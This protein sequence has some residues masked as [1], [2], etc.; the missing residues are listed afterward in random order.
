MR[1]AFILFFLLFAQLSAQDTSN[2]ALFTPP[3]GWHLAD[4]KMLPPSVK[5]MVVGSGTQ[6]FPPSIN[7]G[8]E[9][10]KGTLKNY[11]QIVKTINESQ[12]ATWKDLGKIKTQAGIASLSQV[13]MTTEWG[14]VR[15]MHTILQKEGTVYI[16][17]GASLKDEFSQ[18]SPQFLNSFR[19]LRFNN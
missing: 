8:M 10:Y 1:Y 16:M 5:V 3:E 2:T 18:F 12:G 19:S 13:D 4:P 14:D 7:L 11:L 15:M 17:T 6:A 9:N